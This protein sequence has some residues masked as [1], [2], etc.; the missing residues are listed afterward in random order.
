VWLYD[1]TNIKVT[2]SSQYMQWHTHNVLDG[3]DKLNPN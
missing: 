1:C 3:K 2:D